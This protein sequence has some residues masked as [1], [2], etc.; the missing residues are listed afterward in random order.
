M[1]QGCT[2]TSLQWG[3]W[4]GSGMAAGDTKLLARLAKAGMGVIPPAAGLRALTRLLSASSRPG[5]RAHQTRD[6]TGIKVL[7][8]V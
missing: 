6:R 5:G 1:L 3:A 7:S 8:R 2:S 4:A